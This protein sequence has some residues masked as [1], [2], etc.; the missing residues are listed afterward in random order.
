MAA[1]PWEGGGIVKERYIAVS[2][3]EGQKNIV[4]DCRI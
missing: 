4:L 2:L 1:M 3:D